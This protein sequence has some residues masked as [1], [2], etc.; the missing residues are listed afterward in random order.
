MKKVLDGFAKIVEVLCVIIMCLMVSVVFLATFGRYTGMYAIPWSEEFARYCMISIVYMGL[1][2]ASR[3]GSHFVVEI[4]P[5]I[6]PKPV[7]KAV[8]VVVALM[9][10]RLCRIPG[11]LRLDGLLPDAGPGAAQPYAEA[12]YWYGLYAHPHRC[13]TDGGLLHRSHL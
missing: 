11:P 3:N 12:A 13:R 9:V 1:M 5:M 7:V 2:L 6:F 10:G 4:V 8:S